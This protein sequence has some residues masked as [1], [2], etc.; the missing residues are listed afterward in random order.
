MTGVWLIT[1]T[2]TLLF[3]SIQIFIEYKQ[4]VEK[5]VDQFKIIKL[6]YIPPL[7]QG[8]WEFNN[9]F[10]DIQLESIKRL[11]NIEHIILKSENNIIY[12]HG[13]KHEGESYRFE[14]YVL[15]KNESTLG[16]LEV[17]LNIGNIR[18]G[19]VKKAFTILLG[20]MIKTSIV[21]F[22]LLAF[23]TRAFTTHLYQIIEFVK[24]IDYQANMNLVL[25][26]KKKYGDEFDLLA[27]KINEMQNDLVNKYEQ[28]SDANSRLELS[29][30]KAESANIAKNEFL[31]NM[32]HELRTPM[33]G[34]LSFAK[35][36]VRDIK[37]KKK[38]ISINKLE[39]YFEEIVDSGGRLM[40][41]LNDLLDL[42]KLEAGKMEYRMSAH[43]I[44]AVVNYTLSEFS[45]FA[46]EHNVLL[47][48]DALTE[49]SLAFFDEHK[50]HQ[51]FSNIVS[52][53]IKFSNVG[54]EII[55]SV[56]SNDEDGN[57][58]LK[59]CISNTGV[60]IPED[61]TEVIF[62]K[63]TQ[64]NKTKTKAG[65]TGLGL[66]ICKQI[67]EDHK[68]KIWA[69]NEEDGTTKFY[70]TLPIKEPI[71]IVCDNDNEKQIRYG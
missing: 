2:A 20:Q 67:I 47:K 5:A 64:S 65:G 66:S 40:Y 16:E 34:V 3:T 31:A 45:S 36:G 53:A 68:G 59:I 10:I 26:R 19:Y 54:E 9:N 6:S 44:A 63:F 15:K 60:G 29:L 41:L 30:E 57:N 48:Y 58:S 38:E 51:V 37:T 62:D 23:F 8:V 13:K 4:D 70:F 7:I 71:D 17:S 39:S 61:E 56:S 52:N 32:S 21:C 24:S 25:D 1:S 35:F 22:I 18:E 49:D 42:S 11:N 69:K 43:D 33:H 27:D 28:L 55:I 50:I 14:N 12:S 46:E